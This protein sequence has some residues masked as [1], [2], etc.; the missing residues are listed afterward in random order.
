MILINF[1]VPATHL[2]QV[3]EAMFAAGAGK[4]EQYCNCAWQTL[5]QGQFKPL[6]GSQPFIG[7]VG[8][9]ELIAE[10]KVEMVCDDALKEVVIA[11]LKRAHPYETPAY[12]VI[13]ISC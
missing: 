9:L 10:Y 12:H 11:A 5:G 7:E 1:Y 4:I 3:K 6:T 8:S 13:N 2:N